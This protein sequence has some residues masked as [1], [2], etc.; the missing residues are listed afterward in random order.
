MIPIPL[1]TSRLYIFGVKSLLSDDELVK[2][3]HELIKTRFSDL[4][5]K[6]VEIKVVK[7]DILKKEIH[8]NHLFYR[9]TRSFDYELSN[10][11]RLKIVELFSLIAMTFESI[12]LV[13]D[14][15][16]R[17]PSLGLSRQKL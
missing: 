7:N 11:I 13:N 9:N 3:M 16:D 4:T 6:S 5:Y 17:R 12:T 14:N 8:F 2:T 10:I 15:Y 1:S